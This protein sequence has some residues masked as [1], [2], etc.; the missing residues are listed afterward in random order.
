MLIKVLCKHTPHPTR[1]HTYYSSQPTTAMYCASAD[2]AMQRLTPGVG[3]VAVFL[4]LR[5]SQ[6]R[7]ERSEASPME[8]SLSGCVGCHSSRP[9]G[10]WWPRS[11]TS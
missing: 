4:P 8:A 3:K 2:H 1:T 11:S 7:T 10:S 6:N 5:V 9:T